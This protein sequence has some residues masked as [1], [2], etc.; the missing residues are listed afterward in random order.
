MENKIN[1]EINCK[2]KNNNPIMWVQRDMRGKIEKT[3]DI[4]KTYFNETDNIVT[5]SVRG[6]GYKRS[7]FINEQEMWVFVERV[8]KGEVTIENGELQKWKQNKWN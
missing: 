1:W 2:D 5:L 3:L 7:N 4:D 6:K 8:I